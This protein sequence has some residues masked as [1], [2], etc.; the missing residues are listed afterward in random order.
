MDAGADDRRIVSIYPILLVN[1]VGTLGFSIVLPFLVYLVTKWG[2]N[3]LIF[4]VMGAAYSA[5][6]LIGAPILGRW[7]DVHGRRKILL[8][9]QVGTLLSWVIFLWA[10]FLPPSP[11]L[12]VDSP[13]LGRFV[14]TLPLI[15][16]FVARAADGLT[17]GNVSVAHAYL[18]DLS[19]DANRT[20]NFGKMAVSA[21]LGFILGPALA[22]I[23][24]GT[25]LEELLPVVAALMISLAATLIIVLKLPDS[26][27]CVLE[28]DPE[29][30]SVRKI[31]GQEQTPCFEMRGAAKLSMAGILRLPAVGRLMGIYF[32]VML[33]FNFFYI[34]FPVHAVTGLRW[35]VT[36]TGIF[37][38]VLSLLMV[39]VQGPVLGRLSKRFDEAALIA[40]GSLLLAASFLF[41]GVRTTPP[42]YAGVVLMA[43]GNG[44][45]WPSVVSILAKAAGPR[46][47]GAVQGFAGG[48]GSVA[49]IAGLLAGGVLYDGIGGKLFI[50]SGGVILGVFL[51]SFGLP[52][53]KPA[54]VR[55]A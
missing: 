18:A 5:F 52:R 38:S 53:T 39:A 40:A 2:G 51:M 4:G 22:G 33:G 34:G 16:M 49:S 23:L 46:Y 48:S 54:A 44:I 7:S 55:P 14:V 21:N 9:S 26:K 6:Q 15:V 8:L 28:S 13:A 25:P 17:G 45:M 29:T 10:F 35:S 42:V 47:Q 41:F 27:N 3:A 1:F 32:L 37:F 50:L 43:V 12:E 36:E 30:T 11:L 20:A 31:F 24:G 19:D